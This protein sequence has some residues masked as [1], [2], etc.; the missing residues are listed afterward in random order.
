MKIVVCA[1]Q[2]P[3][4]DTVDAY[5]VAGRLK[6]DSISN[7]LTS[8]GIALLMNAYDVQAIEAALRIRDAGIDCSV[9]VLTLG[10]E[11]SRQMLRPAFAM[12][13]DEA[14]LIADTAFQGGDGLIIAKVLA[15]AIDKLGGADLI[16]CGRQASDDD[17]GVVGPALA[18]ILGVPSATIAS[19][20]TALDD[21]SVRVTR[22]LPDAVEVVALELPALV[23]V[24]NEIGQPRFPR[25][26]AMME[27]R[28]KRPT[29]WSAADLGLGTSDTVS[30]VQQV[31]LSVIEVRGQC[32]FVSGDSI[33][34][35][36]DALAQ[37][38]R[39][40]GLI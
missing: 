38:M 25:A 18:E 21:N 36:A 12:G 17:Q 22:T 4:P 13:A 27:S 19:D 10:A 6:V 39:K 31:G 26:R 7:K 16:L 1:K 34:D 2:V 30:H 5:A 40:D 32:E 11:D 20:V 33:Q 9:T 28:R 15:R 35:K 3:D 14:V 24:S 37:R 8:Q 29:V 23:T